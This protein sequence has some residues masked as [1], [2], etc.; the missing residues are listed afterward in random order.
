ME[1]N[2]IVDKKEIKRIADILYNT[3]V[4]RGWEC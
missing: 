2:K 4:L 1:T 3:Y